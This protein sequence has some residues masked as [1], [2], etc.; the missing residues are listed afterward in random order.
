MIKLTAKFQK[1]RIAEGYLID[2]SGDS[3]SLKENNKSPGMMTRSKSAQQA[4][5]HVLNM[6]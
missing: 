4:T 6:N 5:R 1:L 3:N 2:G